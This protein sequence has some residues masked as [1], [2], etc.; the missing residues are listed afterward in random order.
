MKKVRIACAAL[1]AA[2][3]FSGIS[4]AAA[5]AAPE[6]YR[7]GVKLTSK[8]L[9]DTAGKWTLEGLGIFGPKFKAECD[10]ELTGAVGPGSVDE[11]TNVV[12]LI[13]GKLVD[14]KIIEKALCEGT[15]AL[16]EAELLSWK[17]KLELNFSSEIVDNFESGA[18]DV[19]CLLGGGAWSL[20]L[21]EGPTVTDPL[22]NMA[23]G[24]VAVKVLR[25][26]STRCNNSFNTAHISAEVAIKLVGSGTLEVK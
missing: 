12:E 7:N 8:E 20:E 6:W 2:A 21:C 15:L 26:N 25:Q 10:E 23:N 18:F 11:V 17:S 16:L 3:A 1:L 22:V 14:C 19:R 5:P 4:A 13:G 9:V 24:T